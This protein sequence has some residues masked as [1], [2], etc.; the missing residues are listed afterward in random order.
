MHPRSL[1]RRRPSAPLVIS[2]I[3][4]F[5][6]LGGVGYAASTL[7]SG[8]VGTA[9]LQ[10]SAVTNSKLGNQS[11]GNWKLRF[12]AVG[13]RKLANAAVGTKQINTN[14]V[15]AR[16]TGACLTPGQAV[17]AVSQSGAVSCGE[18]TAPQFGIATKDPVTIT[19]SNSSTQILAD[20][21]PSGSPYLLFATVNA[22][23][24]GSD[25]GQWVKVACTLSPGGT[26]ASQTNTASVHVSDH[27][28]SVAIPLIVPAP[29]TTNN[30]TGSITCAET[31]ASGSAPTV[32][33]AASLNALETASNTLQTTTSK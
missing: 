24:T 20:T 22:T 14:Q 30:A 28:E 17:N 10:D 15:Q 27:P 3:A 11:V 13:S 32:T 26:A 21:L 12:G 23:V 31:H 19:A 33:A 29:S 18:T 1:V 25:P 6:A 16:V 9:Q 4:L 7:P 5:V 2:V 8:S